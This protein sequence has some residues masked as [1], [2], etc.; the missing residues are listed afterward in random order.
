MSKP[1]HPRVLSETEAEATMSNMRIS[2]R[3]LN[4]VAGLIRNAPAAQAV[5]AN[6]PVYRKK[7]SGPKCLLAW[8]TYRVAP[9]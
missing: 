5:A 9:S 4:L 8:C 3:K 1:K 2:A 6:L 7:V